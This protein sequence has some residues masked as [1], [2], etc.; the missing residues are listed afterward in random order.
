MNLLTRKDDRGFTLI[1]LLVVMIIIGILAAIAIPLFLNQ[2]KR[3]HE[4]GAKSDVVDIVQHL[5]SYYIDG[6]LTLTA[7]GGAG[8]L[9]VL[10]DTSGVV[11]SSRLSPGDLIVGQNIVSDTV[12]CV[13]VQHFSGGVPDSR[14]WTYDQDGLHVGNLC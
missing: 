9:W 4:T 7:S 14:A 13:A 3:A 6:T 5:T 10:S 12:F 1:E 8:G 11:D 2:K